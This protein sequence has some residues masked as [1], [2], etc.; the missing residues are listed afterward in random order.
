VDSW[1]PKNKIRCAVLRAVAGTRGGRNAGCFSI[2]SI[3]SLDS[4]RSDVK[5]AIADFSNLDSFGG[6]NDPS[7]TRLK[8]C[9]TH[10]TSE[11]RG[12]AI[13]NDYAQRQL[14]IFTS[15]LSLQNQLRAVE[16]QRC[17]VAR[18]FP[19]SSGSNSNRR[20]SEHRRE[21]K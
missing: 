18:E 15:A 12:N 14:R 5:T 4:C 11:T 17:R 3:P 7:K 21:Q 10:R 16:F 19:F 2:L 9:G 1:R 13:E 6:T 20:R 8:G